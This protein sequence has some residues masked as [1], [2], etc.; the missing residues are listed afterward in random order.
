VPTAGGTS[1]AQVMEEIYGRIVAF[2]RTSIR[3]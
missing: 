2:I 1:Q 3:K